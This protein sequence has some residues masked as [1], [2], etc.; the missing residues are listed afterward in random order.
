MFIPY[1]LLSTYSFNSI[2]FADLSSIGFWLSL[3]AYVGMIYIMVTRFMK[4]KK[5][6]WAFGILFYLATMF[7]FSNFPFLMGAELAERFAFF[8]SA[9]ICLIMALAIEHW[10]VKAQTADLNTLKASKVL[11][12]LVPLCVVYGGLAVA[13]NAEWKDNVTL[14]KADVKRSPN[15]C[16]LYHNVA[17]ALAEEAYMEEPDSL[18]KLKIDDEAITYLVKGLEIYPDYADLYVEMARI[19]DRKKMPDSAVK[20]NTLALKMNPT[21]FTANNNLG[22]VLLT[23]GRYREAIPYFTLAMQFNPNFKYAYLNIARC[24]NQLQQYDSAVINFRKLMEFE[25]QNLDVYSEIGMAFFMMTKYDSA[26]YFYKAILKQKPDDANTINNIGAVMLNTKRYG[27]AVEYFKKA[28]A[29]NPGYFNAYTNLARSYFFSGQYAATIET[30]NKEIQMDQQNAIK[31]IPYI[32]LSYQ[33]M[34]NMVEAKK[35]EATSQKY[36]SNFKLE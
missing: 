25:P 27:E 2:P 36:Y 32:A 24:Y 12:V 17:S 18:K 34:G 1:P 8:G 20:Y 30:V 9:G 23:A 35:W 11:A 29:L 26:E 22:S 6:P 31:D 16:R 3:I 7:L 13:R 14:Y 4:D 15:D 33:K 28:I 5:D 21:N 19:Y 10:I